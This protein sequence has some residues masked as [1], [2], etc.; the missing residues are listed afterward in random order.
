MWLQSA[1]TPTGIRELKNNLSQYIR[2]VEAGERIAVTP[3]GRV[4]A[5]LGPPARTPRSGH[6]TPVD[7][8]VAPRGVRLS[9]DDPGPIAHWPK[10]RLRARAPA[11][12]IHARSGGTQG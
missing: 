3:H 4:V 6:R 9:V 8:L 5:E 1:M 11:R 10:L 12:I 2:R 7:D